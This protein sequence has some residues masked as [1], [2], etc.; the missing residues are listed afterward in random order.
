MM[1]KLRRHPNIVGLRAFWEDSDNFYLVQDVMEGGELF[2]AIVSRKRLSEAEAQR[3]T[4]TLV[5]TLQYC[6]Q[7]CIIHRDLKP[8]N[9]LLRERDNLESICLADFG[10]SRYYEFTDSILSYCGTPGY[11]APEILKNY[12]YGTAVD[13]WSLGVIVYIL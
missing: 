8:E 11:I 1:Y 5:F 9:I 7:R 2:N 6:H 4:L 12:P 13:M 3:L 10:L